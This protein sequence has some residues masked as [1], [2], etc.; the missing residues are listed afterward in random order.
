MPFWWKRRNKWWRGRYRKFYKRRPTYKPRK[1]RLRRY[2]PRRT[3][4]YRHRRRKKVRRKFKKLTL[5]QWQPKFITKCKVKGLQLFC[6][7]AEGKQMLCFTEEKFSWTP[8]K[9]PGGGGFSAEQYTLQYLYNEWTD[10]NNYW[11]HSNATKDLVRYTGCKFTFYKHNKTDFL[12]N[13]S[14]KPVGTIDKYYYCNLHPKELLLRKRTKVV[15]RNTIKPNSKQYVKVRIKPPRTMQ[16]NWYVQSDFAN[17]PL[18]DLHVVACDLIN[19]YISTVDNNQLVTSYALAL[20]F[21]QHPNWGADT[22]T[23]MYRPFPTIATTLTP[24]VDGKKRAPLH[25]GGLNYKQ[26]VS[27]EQGW[28]QTMLLRATELDEQDVLPITVVRYNPKQDTGHGNQIY[29]KHI[30]Q[31]NYNPPT[32]DTAILLGEKPLWQLLYGYISYCQKVKPTENILKSYVL[33]IISPFIFPFKQNEP[34]ILIDS[35][36][37][38]GKGPYD[39]DPTTEQKKLWYPTVEHQQKIINTIVE[40]GPFIPKYGRD[41][42]SSWDLH[43]KYCFYFKWGGEETDEQDAFDPSKQITYAITHDLAEA[44]QI[45]DPSQQIPSSIIHAWDYRRGL[46]TNTALKRIRENIPLDETLSTD[47]EPLPKKKKTN[48]IPVKTQETQEI[49]TCL[50]ELFEESSFHTPEDQTQIIELIQQ[51]HQQQQQLKRNLLHLIADLK[52]QQTSLKMKTGLLL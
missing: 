30:T 42:E 44:I 10:G 2:K 4:R 34:H 16:T 50:Q 48:G 31:L 6:L 37:Y 11:T 45:S 1:R 14:R 47:S 17:K 8:P 51:Q 36:F 35:S 5:K 18:L 32:V 27:Y 49:Q 52:K 21:Y 9:I 38:Q 24:T 26:S 29:I 12:V 23:A 46:L 25:F 15:H 7:G 20:Q 33:C 19:S 13:Y 22:G 39:S 3:T 28:F 40:T 43:G 41:R